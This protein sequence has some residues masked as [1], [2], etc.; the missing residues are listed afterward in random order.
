M[1]KPATPKNQHSSHCVVCPL[2]VCVRPVAG[3]ID[4][5]ANDCCCS[6][7]LQHSAAWSSVTTCTVCLNLPKGDVARQVPFRPK[8]FYFAFAQRRLCYSSFWLVMEI[9]WQHQVNRHSL[10]FHGRW[11]R[12]ST[13]VCGNGWPCAPFHSRSFCL[14]Q[15]NILPISFASGAA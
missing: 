7:C 10:K 8:F 14:C 1:R 2:G 9:G 5:M 12:C 4:S 13:L 11:W 3:W 15:R 6:Y